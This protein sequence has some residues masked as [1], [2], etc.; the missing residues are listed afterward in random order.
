[1]IDN[2]SEC[3]FCWGLKANEEEIPGKK[4]FC[5]ELIVHTFNKYNE[6]Y[7]ETYLIGNEYDLKYCPICGKEIES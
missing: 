4:K 2:E 3:S 1:M 5:V 6:K 7:D